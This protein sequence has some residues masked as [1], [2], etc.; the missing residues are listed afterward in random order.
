[1]GIF[2]FLAI[3]V[4][5]PR[6]TWH[7]VVVCLLLILRSFVSNFDKWIRSEMF[8]L[9]VRTT[10]N[11]QYDDGDFIM[12]SRSLCM[13]VWRAAGRASRLIIWI[14][15]HYCRTLTKCSELHWKVLIICRVCIWGVVLITTWCFWMCRKYLILFYTNIHNVVMKTFIAH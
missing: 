10:K 7:I 1:M 14:L 6:N 4:W 3:F 11:R 15:S 13:L 2:R 12:P 8:R 5:K 9:Y